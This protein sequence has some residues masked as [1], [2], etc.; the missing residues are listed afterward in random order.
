MAIQFNLEE[1]RTSNIFPMSFWIIFSFLRLYTRDRIEKIYLQLAIVHCQLASLFLILLFSRLMFKNCL[2][3][4]RLSECPS[5]CF[6]CRLMVKVFFCCFPRTIL[7]FF[8][9]CILVADFFI[10]VSTLLFS[11]NAWL[12]SGYWTPLETLCFT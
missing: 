5:E 7:N 8:F 10:Y 2:N 4:N 1:K 11:G 12:T 3:E 9:L 6:R